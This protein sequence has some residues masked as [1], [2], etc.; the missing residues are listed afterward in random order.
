MINDNGFSA[1]SI[2]KIIDVV[3]VTKGSFFYHFKNKQELALALI[4]RFAQA[5]REI[6]QS[7]MQ[8]AEKLSDDPLQQV[9]I[10]IG[11]MLEV[12]EELDRDPNPGCLFATYCFESGLFEPASHQVISE[13][14]SEW[15]RQL[16]AK[17]EAA[18]KIQGTT[19]E[20]DLKSLADM[21][22]VIFEGS[23]VMARVFPEQGTFVDQLKHYRSYVRLVFGE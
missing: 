22:T 11:L 9:L 18:K 16:L 2:D 7:G 17:F 19:V 10:F 21:L 4:E 14:F 6:L 13:S 12:A 15:T 8:R 3:G 20:V 1:T 23:F 5:D